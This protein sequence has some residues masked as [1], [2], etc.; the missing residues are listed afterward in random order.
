MERIRLDLSKT[1]SSVASY[2]EI[3]EKFNALLDNGTGRGSDFL[4]W[5][6]LPSSITEEELNAVEAAATILRERCDYVINVGIGGS[7]LGARAVIE[8]LQNS[9]EAY[10][11]D[12]ENP[13]ILYAGNNIGEDYL[14]ELLQFLRDK[15][16]GII[17]ISKSGTTT[18][19][20]IAFRLLKGL[21]ESQVGR[22]DARERI[23]AVTD[24]AKGALRRM[25]DEEGYRSFVIPDNVGG[26]FSVL[27]PVGLLPVAVA[28]FDIR[29][30]VRGAADMQ[31]MTASDIPFSDNPA[32]RYAA[33]RNA[34]YA[35]G[36]KIEILANF[37][38]KMH[39]IGEWWK[40][41]FGESE[42]KEEKGI[43][44]ATV[45]LTTDLHSMG[46][47]MQ[48]GERTIFE[49]VISVENQD[50]CLTIP[51]DSADLDGLNFLAGKRVDEVNK[52]AELGTRLAHVDGGVPNIRII[53]PQ[54]DAYYIGQLF[55][56]FEKAVGVSGY[57]LGV[58]PFDQ[59]G[60]EGYKNNMFA[61]LN[62]P[63]Y[64]TESAAM[65]GR[66]KEC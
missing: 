32:L 21:L 50:T 39:Y 13:V 60:V 31:A 4:G 48:E 56:F 27:T 6:H 10:R 28:G 38:P 23:V 35:E 3:A 24:S 5:V 26:R 19:P 66:L 49:T 7:Y 40:Q 62:K 63:G 33:A 46:Q 55:Y 15:R 64:E 51:S 44:T 8:A 52:M 36:K 16:F 34:L 17:Y 9:F 58:N 25:A 30:L 18:E 43:F 47:W 45:D 53:L 22:E 59:P 65:A 41:L 61:L 42:G 54:L 37:H 29:Q 1:G 2:G 11:S 12:R 20:A 57:M 14:S